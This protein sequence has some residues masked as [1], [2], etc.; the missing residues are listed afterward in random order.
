[1][2]YS[3]KNG[4][5]VEI[6][7]F[8]LVSDVS[9]HIRNAAEYILEELQNYFGI[10]SETE[11]PVV[12]YKFSPAIVNAMMLKGDRIIQLDSIRKVL[13]GTTLKL[14][15]NSGTRY[16]SG[17]QFKYLLFPN[18]AFTFLDHHIV[19]VDTG[20]FGAVNTGRKTTLVTPYAVIQL[21]KAISE[22]N[23]LELETRFRVFAGKAVMTPI[24]DH[25]KPETISNRRSAATRGYSL[26]QKNM[27]DSVLIQG[28]TPFKPVMTSGI[29]KQFKTAKSTIFKESVSDVNYLKSGSEDPMDYFIAAG[30]S[31]IGIPMDALLLESEAWRPGTNVF[32][33]AI[34]ETG[35]YLCKPNRVGPTKP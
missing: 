8:S 11:N 5:S 34:N 17:R 23:S 33:P 26:A 6:S 35:C 10:E 1:M 16:L 18:S 24:M 27:A 12:L 7:N 19:Q 13:K 31:D 32:K 21:N 30:L 15:T 9:K 2:N 22:V 29:V 3:M 20:R 28:F 4:N 25:G 14:G